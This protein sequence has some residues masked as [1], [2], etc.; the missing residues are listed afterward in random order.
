MLKMLYTWNHST[1]WFLNI[2]YKK[3][4]WW[5]AKSILTCLDCLYQQLQK[6]SQWRHFLLQQLYT[7]SVNKRVKL[8]NINSPVRYISSSCHGRYAYHRV[9][10]CHSLVKVLVEISLWEIWRSR[11][12][13]LARKSSYTLI[14]HMLHFS[15]L[16]I[17]IALDLHI[18][19]FSHVTI[20]IIWFL[21]IQTNKSGR[22][23]KCEYQWV[24]EEKRPKK[25]IT[26]LTCFDIQYILQ[27]T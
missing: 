20:I 14:I 10:S 26:Q 7:I 1:D 8:W 21:K 25:L 13:K 17:D 5:Q 23:F 11:G 22:G 15:Q 18:L 3:V 6:H 2:W 16:C 12:E 24:R 4:Q 27:Q 19:I 9:S